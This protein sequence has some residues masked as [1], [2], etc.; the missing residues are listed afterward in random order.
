VSLFPNVANLRQYLV[1]SETGSSAGTPEQADANP[2][3]DIPDEALSR[4]IH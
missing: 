3:L 1:K 2:V 4:N